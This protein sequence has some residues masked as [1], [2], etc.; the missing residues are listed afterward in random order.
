MQLE[1]DTAPGHSGPTRL[2]PLAA[3]TIARDY[4]D[5][6]LRL[7]HHFCATG[8]EAQDAAQ[9]AFVNLVEALP[10]FRGECALSTWVYRITLNTCRARGRRRQLRQQ[11]E[12]PLAHDPP[13]AELPAS[14]RL[15]L[16]ER[17]QALRQAVTELPADYRA[18]VLLHYHQEL[19]YEEVAEVLGIPLGTVKVRLFRAKQLLRRRLGRD[20]AGT[21]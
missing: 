7:A 15:E 19:S 5:L 3:E 14:A 17:Q 21:P 11:R 18:V 4:G 13:S 12:T 6:I 1:R 9:E 20:A 16:D 8:D 10:A 2:V